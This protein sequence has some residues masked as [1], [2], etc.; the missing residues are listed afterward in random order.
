MQTFTINGVISAPF[1]HCRYAGG[2]NVGEE[3]PQ[4]DDILHIS[5]QIV[6]GPNWDPYGLRMGRGSSAKTMHI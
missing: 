6:I 3:L 5:T 4:S 2:H 1:L